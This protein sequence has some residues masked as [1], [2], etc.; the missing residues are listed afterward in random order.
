MANF[1]GLSLYFSASQTPHAL[2]WQTSITCNKGPKFTT[3][4]FGPHILYIQNTS[5]LD[6]QMLILSNKHISYINTF[7]ATSMSILTS[8]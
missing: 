5:K 6:I 7:K 1:R 2:E 4:T 3:V 8:N